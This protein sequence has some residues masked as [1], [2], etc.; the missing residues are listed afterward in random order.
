MHIK[1]ITVYENLAIVTDLDTDGQITVEGHGYDNDRDFY[2]LK[3]DKELNKGQKI[4]V[5]LA[6]EG[7]L[8]DKLAGFYRSTYEDSETNTTR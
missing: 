6:F 2:V 3:L 8:N 1:D 5:A 7:E 4:K